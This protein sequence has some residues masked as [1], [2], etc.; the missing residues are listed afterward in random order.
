MFLQSSATGNFLGQDAI[1]FLITYLTRQKSG[2]VARRTTEKSGERVSLGR[3]VG[4]EVHL[5]DLRILLD[6]GA[7]RK[8]IQVGI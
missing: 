8:P 3:G 6:Q 5:S 4:C 7:P 2:N 1:D